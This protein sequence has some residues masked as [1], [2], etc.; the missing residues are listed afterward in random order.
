MKLSIPEN[1]EGKA[2]FE[3]L[4]KNKNLL[5]TEKKSAM[6]H[7]DAFSVPSSLFVNSDGSITKEA[8]NIPEDANKLE[9]T[10]IINTTNYFDSHR[11]VHIPGIWKKNLSESKDQI[12]LAQ[13]NMRFEDVIADEDNVKAFTKKMTW[14]ELGYDADGITEALVFKAIIERKRN[15]FM[16]DQYRN[17]YVKNHSVGMQYV[18]IELAVNSDEDYYKEEFAVWNKYIDEIVN[19]AEAEAV[20][21]FWAIKEA[22]AIEGSA[23]VKGSN[24]ITPTYSIEAKSTGNAP[25]LGTQ[26]QPQKFDVMEAIKKTTFFNS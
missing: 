14:R 10:L 22:K 5:I 26:E 17:G 7:A 3:F 6:K 1:L 9:A 13:H 11:D 20:G 23:V 4:K 21:Y 2:L 24:R 25:P 16:F 12:L 19:G 18:R 15:A 8:T